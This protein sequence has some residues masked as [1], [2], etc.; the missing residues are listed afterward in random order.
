MNEL[1]NQLA[2]LLN[3]STLTNRDSTLL[4]IATWEKLKSAA[5]RELR[6]RSVATLQQQ[7]NV[8][9]AIDRIQVMNIWPW[10]GS[11]ESILQNVGTD[12]ILEHW[13]LCVNFVRQEFAG[14]AP[15]GTAGPGPQRM[16]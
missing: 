16:W 8:Q 14:Q 7:N 9:D 11:L 3:P 13:T 2:A 5:L 12:K 15:T 6:A 1:L 10:G 4:V